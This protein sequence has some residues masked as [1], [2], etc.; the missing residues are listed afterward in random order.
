MAEP[1]TGARYRSFPP[2]VVAE[3]EENER[4]RPTV[5]ADH[6]AERDVEL[7]FGVRTALADDGFV[8]FRQLDGQGR[9]P[10]EPSFIESS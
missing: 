3:P 5:S 10:H 6:G 1:E 7:E 2:S 9:A 8:L 4:A